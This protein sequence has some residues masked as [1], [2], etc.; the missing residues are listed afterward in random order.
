MTI[1]CNSLHKSKIK[2]VYVEPNYL[3]TDNLPRTIDGIE[4][5][6]PD[7][8]ELK[9]LIKT[10][11]GHLTLVRIIPLKTNQSDFFIN[12]I[13]F[14]TTYKRNNFK[15]GNGGGLSIHYKFDTNLGGLT[16]EKHEFSGI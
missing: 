5:Q 7:L 4:I 13:P 1:Y 3:F 8:K 6:Y 2:T 10:N 15:L 11:G 9:K 16:Y 12:I 14:Y